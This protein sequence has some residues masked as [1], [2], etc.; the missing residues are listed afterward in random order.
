[1]KPIAFWLK[2]VLLI[3]LAGP[4][5]TNGCDAPPVEE[6]RI[7]VVFRFDDYSALSSTAAELRIIDEFRKNHAAVTFSVIPFVCD[8]DIHDPS[9][10]GRVPLPPEKAAILKQG[11]EEGVLDIALH[12]YSHQTIDARQMTEFSGLDYSLQLQRVTRG[13]GFLEAITGTPVATFVPPWNQYDPVTLRALVAAGFS[14]L[15]ADGDG[16]MPRDTRLDYLPFTCGLGRLREALP[17]ARA[18]S[19]TRPIVVVL[20]HQY[21][22][23]EID[24]KR[25]KVTFQE[26]GH[27][28]NWLR[29][30]KDIRLLSIRQAIEMVAEK[31]GG[32]N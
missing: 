5:L 10:M 2:A 27:L 29:S 11:I 12:G 16:P 26:F 18:S 14:T 8:G 23:K 31:R 13:R 19:D 3:S 24:Q 25:G 15:S 22:F 6:K 1:M 32:R 20:F 4:F 28:L 17:E 21:D 7:L 9:P 30:Q